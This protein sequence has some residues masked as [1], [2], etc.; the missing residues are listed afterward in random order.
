MAPADVST[1]AASKR[2]QPPELSTDSAL[3]EEPAS[4]T[5]RFSIATPPI[6]PPIS[7]PTSQ[8]QKRDG[9]SAGSSSSKTQRLASIILTNG[10]KV[11]I[12]C[13]ED[14]EELKA[15]ERDPI[16]YENSSEFNTEDLKV[17]MKKEM[18]SRQVFWLSAF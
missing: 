4:K 10:Q 2:E 12:S 14:P 8:G 6:S 13:N 11:K 3:G 18:R 15:S 9:V 5:Q 16:I 7:P 17:A 1:S